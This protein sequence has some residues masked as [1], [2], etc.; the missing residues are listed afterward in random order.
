MLAVRVLEFVGEGLLV[1]RGVLRLYG[2]AVQPQCLQLL[3]RGGLVHIGF[4]FEKPSE[5]IEEERFGQDVRSE[6]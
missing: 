3:C 6:G 2:D 1:G 4:A 5:K